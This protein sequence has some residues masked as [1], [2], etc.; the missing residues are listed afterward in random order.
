L[1]SGAITRIEANSSDS[2]ATPPFTRAFDPDDETMMVTFPVQSYQYWRFYFDDGSNPDTYIEIGRL[3]LCMHW[4]SVDP[5]NANFS[6][7]LED[8][9]IVSASITGQSYADIGVKSRVLKFSL[10][11]LSNLDRIA[12]EAIIKACGTHEPIV[13]K[14]HAAIE[15]LYALLTAIPSFAQIG[16]LNWRDDTLQFKEAF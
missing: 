14:P 13:V 10:G 7:I 16:A 12:L 11:F 6:R 1:T 15:T 3:F 5:I 4:E 2:W 8:T 9:T